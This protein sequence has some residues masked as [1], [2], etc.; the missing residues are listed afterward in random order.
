M[1]SWIRSYSSN[2]WAES[3][4]R[5]ARLG[6]STKSRSRFV[7]VLKLGTV[8][9]AQMLTMIFCS[10]TFYIFFNLKLKLKWN[11]SFCKFYEVVVQLKA[12]E[13]IVN[14]KCTPHPP[15]N[16]ALLPWGEFHSGLGTLELRRIL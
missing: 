12:L 8:F 16:G 3:V 11:L 5:L 9:K 15:L 10:W 1:T 6:Y 4:I 2:T 7:I 13:R 14:A